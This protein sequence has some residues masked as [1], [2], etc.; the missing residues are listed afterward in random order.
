MPSPS[1]A[2]RT[3]RFPMQ[4][5]AVFWFRSIDYGRF[6]TVATRIT[7]SFRNLAQ[8]VPRFDSHRPLHK[9]DDSVDLIRLRYLNP[10]KKMA[11]FARL[12]DGTPLNE[13]VE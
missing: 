9:P 13:T 6:W 12:L 2:N 8:F 10:T 5:V 11:P 1:F 3:S 7:R 4:S